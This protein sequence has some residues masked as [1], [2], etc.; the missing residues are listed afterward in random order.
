MRVVD[1]R[2]AGELL[3]QGVEVAV[4]GPC[5][6]V[7]DYVEAASGAAG[8]DVDQVGFGGGPLFGAVFLGVSAEHE[9]D[10]V[11]FFALGGAALWTDET[12]LESS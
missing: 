4:L 1:R 9:D 2:V 3:G 10:D 7:A 6:V 5:G 12:L 8:G 11:G